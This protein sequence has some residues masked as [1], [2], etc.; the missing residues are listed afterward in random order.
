M[1]FIFSGMTGGILCSPFISGIVYAR[2]GYYP[3]FAMV[4]AVLFVDLF[5]R[6]IM[7][8]KATAALWD[9]TEEHP[10]PKP[11][12]RGV[13]KASESPR[14]HQATSPRDTFAD[15]ELLQKPCGS[16]PEESSS[17][18]RIS[19]WQSID[20]QPDAWPHGPDV[21]GS[22]PSQSWFTRRFA[23]TAA[24]LGSRRLMTAVSGVFIYMIIASSLDG[25]LAQFVKRTFHFDSFGAGIMFLNISMPAVFGTFYG[26]LSDRYGP[27]NLALIGFIVAALGL[28]L[29][30]LIT[31]DSNAQKAGLSILLVIIG[32]EACGRVVVIKRLT[33]C[34]NWK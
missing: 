27:R 22:L 9:E 4:T 25:I 17:I 6:F 10:S 18:F 14:E 24:I 29:S 11:T 23:S 3:V 19:L 30:V 8:E 12:G 33:L 1:G 28:A 21:A 7:I 31:H 13:K 15:D 32:Q 34:R 16:D 5:L 20:P 26:A 2:A